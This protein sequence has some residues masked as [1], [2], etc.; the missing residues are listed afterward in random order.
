MRRNMAPVI[1]KPIAL[2]VLRGNT[3]LKDFPLAVLTELAKVGRWRQL[4]DGEAFAVRN[5]S[6]EG[7]ALVL[8]GAIRSSNFSKEGREIMYTLVTPGKL[9]GLVAVMDGQGSLHDTRAS[10]NTLLFVIPAAAFLLILD[11]EPTLY[12]AIAHMLCYRMRKALSA[13][14]ELG[15]ASL[16][17]RLAR[18]LCTFSLAEGGQNGFSREPIPLTQEGLAALVGGTRSSINRE[19]AYMERKGLVARNYGSV[20]IVNYEKLRELCITSEIFTLS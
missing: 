16:R 11:R 13:V 2:D 14:D 1:R 8:H 5:Q 9:V 10:G 3:W 19:L 6:P 18:Q 12:R 7:L 20:S 17:Q 4:V 15:L